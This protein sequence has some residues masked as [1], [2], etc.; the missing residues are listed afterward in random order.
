MEIHISAYHLNDLLL[1]IKS[2]GKNVIMKG[3]LL[4]QSMYIY[5]EHRNNRNFHYCLVN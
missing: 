4:L 3:K 1:E 5:K 2:Q